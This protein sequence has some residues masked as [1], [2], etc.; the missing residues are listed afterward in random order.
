MTT[1][2]EFKYE[3]T[4]ENTAM[5]LSG[6][7]RGLRPLNL[8]HVIPNLYDNVL[9][10]E[11]DRLDQSFFQAG[12]KG[13]SHMDVSRENA[14]DLLKETFSQ[15]DVWVKITK[16]CGEETKAVIRPDAPVTRVGDDKKLIITIPVEQME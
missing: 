11:C 2:I 15:T 9:E 6:Q 1:K 13:K 14:F 10:L 5:Q 3:R 12:A 4:E 7:L 8:S 16:E